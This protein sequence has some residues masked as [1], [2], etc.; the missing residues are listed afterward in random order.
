MKISTLV[1]VLLT[2]FFWGSSFVAIKITLREVSPI[3][4]VALRFGIG[5]LV[6]IPIILVRGQFHW[7]SRND[8][9]WLVFLGLIGVTIH[10]L[11]QSN[12]LLTTTAI[13]S[14]WIVSLIPIFTAILAWLILHELFTWQK[15]FG[16]GLATCGVF[17]VISRGQLSEG[18]FK[19]PATFGDILLLLSAP[20]WALF[21]VFSKRVMLRL[22]PA[23]SVMY[24][25]VFGWLAVLPLF[26]GTGNW[27]EVSHLTLV[28]WGSLLFLGIFASGLA[29]IF[30]FDALN[31]IGASRL[32]S[33]QYLQPL[34]TLITAVWI[35]DESIMWIT[36]LG[37]F[38]TLAGVWLVNHQRTMYIIRSKL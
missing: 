15:I 34:I 12:G 2:L 8:I 22:S 16:L 35:L 6:L 26:F 18:I 13:N 10:Q 30:W 1:K 25:M 36:L 38:I 5:V 14:G 29:Y 28:G 33:F 11:L 17:L 19:I 27:V 9:P 37:G 4:L 3:T 23:L 21:T 32:T 7:P 24:I 31:D 20:N